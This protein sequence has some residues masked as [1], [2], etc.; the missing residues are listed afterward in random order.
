MG[1]I[2][3]HCRESIAVTLDFD[4]N[5]LKSHELKGKV[6]IKVLESLKEQKIIDVVTYISDENKT[7]NLI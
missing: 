6:A 4:D 7:L 1:K 3:Y 2:L 5:N